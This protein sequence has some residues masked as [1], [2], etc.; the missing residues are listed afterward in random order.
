MLEVVEVNNLI[1]IN[2]IELL[3]ITIIFAVEESKD[4]AIKKLEV[5][6]MLVIN[7]TINKEKITK[8]RGL[9]SLER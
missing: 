3:I 2:E 4:L 5:I 1:N 8:R 9:D 7:P 6:N